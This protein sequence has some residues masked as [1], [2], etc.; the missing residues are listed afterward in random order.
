MSGV[1]KACQSCGWLMITCRSASMTTPVVAEGAYN[2]GLTKSWLV[3]AWSQLLW[4]HSSCYVWCHNVNATRLVANACTRACTVREYRS[5]PVLDRYWIRGLGFTSASN[6]ITGS[7]ISWNRVSPWFIYNANQL[8]QSWWKHELFPDASPRLQPPQVTFLT[9]SC[10]WRRCH[11]Y[12][13]SC[14]YTHIRS[15]QCIS[16]L[17]QKSVSSVPYPPLHIAPHVV[18]SMNDLQQ[19]RSSLRKWKLICDNASLE[20]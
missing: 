5:S 14:T 12:N 3:W 17:T 6:S 4:W 18:K 13:I 20:Y 2:S 9:G 11:H 16:K 1:Q 15:A 10:A 19:L 7:C 8:T